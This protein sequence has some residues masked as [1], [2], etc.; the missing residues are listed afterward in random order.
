VCV[1]STPIAHV[2]LSYTEW[3]WM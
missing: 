3:L 2:K 1:G